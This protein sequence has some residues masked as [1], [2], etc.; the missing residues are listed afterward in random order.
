MNT[1][2]IALL[3]RE[4]L[5][6]KNIWR[7]PLILIGLAVLVRLSLVIGNL[8]FDIDVPDIMQLDETVSDVK[9]SVVANALNGMNF[10]VMITMFA[11]AI[12]YALS[13]LYN[14]RQDD[15]VLFWRSLPISDHTTIASKLMIGLVVIPFIIVVCQALLA[16]LFMGAQSLSYLHH[17]YGSSLLVLIKIS[18]W[19]LLPIVAWCMLCSSI[20]T[21]NPFLLAF[22][23]PLILILIDK[24]FLS[25]TISELFVINRFTGLSDHSVMPLITG[26][27]FS[28]VCIGVSIVKRSQRI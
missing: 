21:K 9:N 1:V 2:M 24:L 28:V 6:H 3:K 18:L 7:V 17:F 20:A 27:I 22:V 14:E 8:S 16:L 26:L 12:F 5:E 23:A 10:I 15:S 13:C 25:G 11:V 19:S 4:V